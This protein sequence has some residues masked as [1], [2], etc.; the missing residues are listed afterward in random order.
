MLGMDRAIVTSIPGTTRDFLEETCIVDE[1]PVR[2]V[3]TAGLRDTGCDIEWQGVQKA[4]AFIK[5]ADV[6]VVVID[7]SQPLGDE[8]RTLLRSLDQ[9]K[10]IAVLNKIDLGSK[11]TPDDVAGI[12]VVQTC[13]V[14]NEGV[15]KLRQAIAT[16]LHSQDSPIHHGAISERH[17]QLIVAALANLQE[18]GEML[19][20]GS[21]DRAV[22]V[23]EEI[24]LALESLG[25][26]TGRSYCDE[27]LNLI[28]SR[29]C[30]GK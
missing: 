4:H 28:F 27:L 24:R 11:M 1:I 2:L 13:L 3:D 7:S 30:I 29:F 10:T 26:I 17:R 9:A 6:Q 12:P 5:R 16:K 20:E 8:D 21:D 15:D 19:G 22:L 25:Q 14:R 18:A 23:A